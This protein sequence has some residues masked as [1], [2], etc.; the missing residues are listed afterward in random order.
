MFRLEISEKPKL[1]FC[2][3]LR[4]IKTNIKLSE[5]E[6]EIFPKIFSNTPYFS[7]SRRH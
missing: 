7:W 2:I 1:R 4:I 6:I 5:K 3:D